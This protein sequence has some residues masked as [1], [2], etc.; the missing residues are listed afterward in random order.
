MQILIINAQK[1]KTINPLLFNLLRSLVTHHATEK[2]NLIFINQ[3]QKPK[4]L[5]KII[6]KSEKSSGENSPTMVV[7]IVFPPKYNVSKHRNKVAVMEF[8]Q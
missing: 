3:E 6:K 4:R 5:W 7:F 8:I 1:N 2:G